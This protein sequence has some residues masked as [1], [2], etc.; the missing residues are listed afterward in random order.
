MAPI[1]ITLFSLLVII[2]LAILYLNTLSNT[3]K[4]IRY[5]NRT[6]EP[7]NVWYM[8]IPFYNYYFAFTM[9][10]DVAQSIEN[11]F[12]SRDLH[13]DSKPTYAIGLAACIA[14]IIVASLNIISS[15]F[16]TYDAT[17]NKIKGYAALGQLA[18]WVGHWVQVYQYKKKLKSLPFLEDEIPDI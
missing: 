4:L 7:G 15:V 2:S 12:R 17:F 13:I 18:L 11:E 6:L 3:L 10:K 16:F 14:V 8:L 1:L 9:V 5:E